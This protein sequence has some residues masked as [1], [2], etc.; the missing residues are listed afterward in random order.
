[1]S[2]FERRI[3]FYLVFAFLLGAYG[4]N[5]KSRVSDTNKLGAYGTN[6]EETKEATYL[7]K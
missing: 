6:K 4:T 7:Y 3:F 5:K 1:M 2:L